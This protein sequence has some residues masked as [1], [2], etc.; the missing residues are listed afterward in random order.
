MALMP[1]AVP[2]AP[3][4]R[5]RSCEPAA[6]VW[7]HQGKLARFIHPAM[8]PAAVLNVPVPAARVPVPCPRVRPLPRRG[9]SS[10]SWAA[11][12]SACSMTI[13]SC[14][15]SMPLLGRVMASAMTAP[16]LTAPCC[17]ESRPS[18]PALP[19]CLRPAEH[20]RRVLRFV[21]LRAGLIGRGMCLL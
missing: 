5:P 10:A 17:P 19:C 3:C 15:T 13:C 18:P 4:A 21:R 20:G 8:R 1:L 14:S 6:W 7:M 12:R 2:A 11:G 16:S 9:A